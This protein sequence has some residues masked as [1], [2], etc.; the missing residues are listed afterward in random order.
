MLFLLVVNKTI[1]R[2]C[3]NLIKSN[4]CP[5]T[6]I[7]RILV[8]S[9]GED[10]PP[11]HQNPDFGLYINRQRAL[12]YKSDYSTFTYTNEISFERKLQLMIDREKGRSALID[13]MHQPNDVMR[14]TC[15]T[16]SISNVYVSRSR[17]Q[18]RRCFKH[19]H[20]LTQKDVYTDLRYRPLLYKYVGLLESVQKSGLSY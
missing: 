20:F 1:T 5:L 11:P 17:T 8:K 2:S 9:R 13:V 7:S 18:L 19:V 4:K 16:Y 6:C 12:R 14:S 3:K 15:N 10:K